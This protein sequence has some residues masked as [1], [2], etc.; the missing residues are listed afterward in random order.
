[1]WRFPDLDRGS[2]L[3]PIPLR[4]TGGNPCRLQDCTFVRKSECANDTDAPVS[5]FTKTSSVV[6]TLDFL[7]MET[8]M[9]A[10][11]IALGFATPCTILL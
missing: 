11:V 7:G 10:S 8:L 1:M 4:L 6:A 3:P 5:T 2:A 9:M